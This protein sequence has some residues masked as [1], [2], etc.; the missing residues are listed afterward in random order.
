MLCTRSFARKDSPNAPTTL[1]TCAGT[2]LCGCRKRAN[3]SP[4][5][6]NA[7]SAESSTPAIQP[8]FPTRL[9]T[10]GK[11]QIYLA[12]FATR[13]LDSSDWLGS[14]SGLNTQTKC[15]NAINAPKCFC[16]SKIFATTWPSTSKSK[17]KFLKRFI[18]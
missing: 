18:N 12:D 2:E 17:K 7:K 1:P 4:C 10:K 11:I 6:G 13:L 14:I 15:S 3:P 16:Q 9:R 8:I 5:R